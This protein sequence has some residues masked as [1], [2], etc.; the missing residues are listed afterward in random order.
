MGPLILI[1]KII[2]KMPTSIVKILKETQAAP[3]MKL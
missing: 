2:N 1:A 3:I